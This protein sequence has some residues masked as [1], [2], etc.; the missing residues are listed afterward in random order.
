MRPSVHQ[1]PGAQRAAAGE[2][3]VYGG[4]VQRK[5][6]SHSWQAAAAA[7]LQNP[8][9]QRVCA[10]AVQYEPAVHAVQAEAAWAL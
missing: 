10:V 8:L 2:D 1:P 6:S 5:P 7:G 9:G 3:E 4:E